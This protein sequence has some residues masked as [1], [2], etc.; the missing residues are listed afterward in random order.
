MTDSGQ[1]VPKKPRACLVC[2]QRKV[3]CN[4][5]QVGLP[6]ST[7]VRSKLEDRCRYPQK[8]RSLQSK[9]KW[10]ELDPAGSTR[11]GINHAGVSRDENENAHV[12]P[13]RQ[14]P[15]TIS[16]EAS[17]TGQ[18][19]AQKEATSTTAQSVFRSV[20]DNATP[21]SV[22]SPDTTRSQSVRD[23]DAELEICRQLSRWRTDS[24]T[25]TRVGDRDKGR[26][27]IEYHD[28]IYSTTI[29]GEV[30]GQKKPR[31]LVR[32]I[33]SEAK[34]GEVSESCHLSE[35]ELTYLRSQKA[36]D[37]P[38]R[39]TC[40]KIL[41]VFFEC[42]HAYAPVMDRVQ[43][44]RNYTNGSCSIVLMQAVM[45]N[46][47]PF[48]SNDLIVEMGFSTR[49]EAQ[50]T[51]LTR[52]QLLYDFDTE[53]SPLYLLQSCF[54]LSS[55]HTVRRTNKDYR[56]WFGNAVRI[57]FQ[58]GLHRKV[59]LRDLDTST[60]KLFR[61][62]WSVIRNRDTLLT[63]AGHSNV[64]L[65]NDDDSD[66]PDVGEDDWEE[67]RDCEA[68]RNVLPPVTR[69]Q[70]LYHVENT[71]LS[72]ISADF[73]RMFR[74]NEHPPSIP[75]CQEF[76]QSI[77]EWQKG[78]PLE[79]HSESVR[80]WSVENVWILVLRALACRLEC[81][82]YRT[83]RQLNRTWKKECLL[84]SKQKQEIAMF[85]LD[86][87]IDRL[88]I[89]N[90]VGYC[91]SFIYMCICTITAMHIENA[92]HTATSPQDKLAARLRIHKNLTCL[93]SNSEP[94]TWLEFMIRMLEVI[95]RRTGLSLDSV[96]NA[97]FDI[98]SMNPFPERVERH[99]S[100]QRPD[101]RERDSSA[102]PEGNAD[103]DGL[104]VDGIDLDMFD[105]MMTPVLDPFDLGHNPEAWVQEFL[106][107]GITG[108]EEMQQFMG[109]A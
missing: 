65:I 75:R 100:E 11:S 95:I 90:L 44:M 43:F 24:F 58:M 38:C 73:C 32:L 23:V 9:R 97:D 86:S 12:V 76:E 92:L 83:I 52:A 93:R 109:E 16:H 102:R 21:A 88:V 29:L 37:L 31:R 25:S 55:L 35:A 53:R 49:A 80:S 27:I 89:H 47:M 14:G 4:A 42:V 41:R 34:P 82:F 56:F 7:C 3:R 63:I 19:P 45:A 107:A 64:R 106:E 46:A 20:P 22:S 99:E 84:A 10:S 57:A 61:R 1:I 6:C 66:M 5:D 68:F 67:E 62:M 17:G 74:N 87:T 48:I 2:H 71:K 101:P 30:F 59:I 60:Q 104:T 26:E 33:L 77:A 8:S 50:R 81:V 78:L 94:W 18:R 36:F 79:L 13:S 85:E 39:A 69:L 105:G 40:D 96:E 70:R 15:N 108:F 98:A 72:H 51:F 28:G 54:F 91:H 103:A